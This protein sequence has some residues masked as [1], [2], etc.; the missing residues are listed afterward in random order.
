MRARAWAPTIA[1]RLSHLVRTHDY[2][3]DRFFAADGADSS[4]GAVRR[5][6]LDR[7]GAVARAQRD[8]S[9]AW[10]AQVRDSFSDLRFTDANRVPFPFAREM[11]ERFDLSTVVTASDGPRLR[12]L[13]GNWTLDV[14]G[15]YG[16]NVAGFNRYKDW[17][18]AG[19]E[20]VRDVGPVLGPLHPVVAENLT[21][22]RAISGQDEVS[23][24]MSGT[25]AVMAAVRLA[26]FNTRRKL[27]VCFVGAYHGWWDGVIA[28]L[29]SERR[30]DD[31]LAL[32]GRRG[33]SCPAAE[34]PTLALSA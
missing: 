27:I 14:S 30:I 15:A 17:I 33:T 32:Q 11:R 16:V 19:W 18:S 1:R 10:N 29:G 25:E 13:D 20:R 24:H 8:Q 21:A 4:V 34:S 9:L 7:L 2:V 12:D 26:R 3:G 23:F 31:C 6:A 28:G 22:L 5:A